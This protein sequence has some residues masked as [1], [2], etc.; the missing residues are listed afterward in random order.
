MILTPRHY[1][2]AHW[3]ENVRNGLKPPVE[4]RAPA[5]TPFAG[6]TRHCKQYFNAG[7][8]IA[9]SVPLNKTE[10][11]GR[12]PAAPPPAVPKPRTIQGAVAE[13]YE[14]LTPSQR[15]VIDRLLKDTRYGALTSAQALAAELGVSVATVTRA[16]QGLHFQG[17]PD[18][19]AHLR[20]RLAGSVP[21][22][23][24]SS[25]A[26]LG[27]TADTPV[28]RVMIED[29]ESVRA[30]IEDLDHSA[31]AEVVQ[32]L[33]A[34]RRVFVFGAR[35]SHGLAIILAI[36][37]RLL[38]PDAR[39]LSQAAGDLPDQVL[40]LRSH[41]AVVVISV[42]RVDRAGVQLLKHAR[43]MRAQSI[44]L[45]DS[46]S[47]PVARLSNHILV[48]RMGPLRVM[49]SYAAAASLINALTTAV[50]LAR[51]DHL[52]AFNEAERLWEEFG[53]Y[54]EN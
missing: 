30:T 31:F 36:G 22:R 9:R 39:L 5:L 19:Q 2:V 17:F 37:L 18:L 49:P 45:V 38:L 32:T 10:R 34:A 27:A 15:R 7:V 35:G 53:T 44:G 24:E 4:G 20:V 3:S 33:V 29:A 54:A 12:G 8:A 26:E 13:H 25:L 50:S 28:M 23:I 46:L 43:S 52:P 21:Q 6:L 47:S 51:G 40:G 16:A 1:T 42:R 48:A 14:E 11:N 41:D